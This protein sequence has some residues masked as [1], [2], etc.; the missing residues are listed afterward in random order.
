MYRALKA[1]L[2]NRV[3]EGRAGISHFTRVVRAAFLVSFLRDVGVEQL[4]LP[5]EE[6]VSSEV[7]Q[8]KDAPLVVVTRPPFVICIDEL[9]KKQAISHAIFTRALR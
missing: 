2:M 8:E 7:S 1:I 9:I 6:K 3:Y 5:E 4:E